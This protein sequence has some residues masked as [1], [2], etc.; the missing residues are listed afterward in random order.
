[1]HVG[2]IGARGFGQHHL[3]G[4][5]ASPH[6][7]AI[8]L[9]GRD[10][11]ALEALRR[12]HPKVH[13]ITTNYHELLDDARIDLIDVVV[14]H[15]L[16]LPIALEAFARGKHVIMEK[17]PA[18]TPEEFRQMIAGAERAERRLFVVMN[19]LYT[20][21]HRAARAVVDSGAIGR[22]FYSVEVSVGSALGIYQDPENWRADRERCGGGL[23]I[24][25]GFHGV[26]RQLYFLQRLGSPT[27]LTADCAQIGVDAP[28]KG[29]DFS[30]LTLAYPDG[31]RVHLCNQWTARATLGR[32]P[33]GILGTEGSLL[34]TGDPVAPLLLRRPAQD[35]EPVP[36][37]VGPSGFP[38]SVAACVAH[39]VEC[40]ATG[41][42]PYAGLDLAMLTLE[43]IT[44]AYRSAE[45]GSRVYL[46][47]N[48][49][50]TASPPPSPS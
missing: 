9:A 17:P 36:L 14:P 40:L 24:D 38:E 31:E 22:P 21:V 47:T 20:A 26:Y 39:Y 4:L 2:L 5:E 32:F 37:P 41:A 28:A 49:Q 43:I 33:S 42:E 12:Q 6:V 30:T 44:G 8:T 7:E 23:Q 15:D 25:G 34:F 19:L 16:H 46:Q 35:D 3:R 18:R 10:G 45:A 1:M 27:W 11:A 29:E 48:L 13:A 50:P